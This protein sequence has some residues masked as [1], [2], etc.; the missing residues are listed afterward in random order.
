[1][2]HTSVR[3]LQCHPTPHRTY[4]KNYYGGASDSLKC[5]RNLW[6]REEVAEKMQNS[7]PWGHFYLQRD[8]GIL[9][10]TPLEQMPGEP[11]S[12]IER[13]AVRACDLSKRRAPVKAANH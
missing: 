10:H 7:A 8:L 5:V 13:R 6:A 9:N 3:E 4:A 11:F 1:V 2:T 12:T